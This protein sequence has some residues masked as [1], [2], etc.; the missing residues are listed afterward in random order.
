MLKGIPGILSPELFSDEEKK[1][2]RKI[3]RVPGSE[4]VVIVY[5]QKREDESREEALA[6]VSAGK[7]RISCSIPEIGLELHTLCFA[8]RMD[9]RGELQSLENGD[10][11]AFMKYFP[12]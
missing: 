11:E 5:N 9:E 4:H 2:E 12:M 1:A 6:A 7:P 8:C 3:V 10:A